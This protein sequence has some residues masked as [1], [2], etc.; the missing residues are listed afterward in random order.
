MVEQSTMWKVK[1]E[2]ITSINNEQ[3]YQAMR[4]S[5]GSNK[6]YDIEPQLV[7]FTVSSDIF[8]ATAT[9]LNTYKGVPREDGIRVGKYMF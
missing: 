7:G 8:L 9:Q 3:E 4:S 6:L 5:S 2:E 1:F